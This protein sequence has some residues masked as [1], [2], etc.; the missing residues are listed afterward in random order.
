MSGR[1][2]YI[3]SKVAEI[4]RLTFYPLPG[5]PVKV[6]QAMKSGGALVVVGVNGRIYTSQANSRTYWST[7]NRMSDTVEA[8]VKFGMLSPQAIEQHKAAAKAESDA[9]EMRY[10]SSAILDNTDA[11]GIKL[12]KAQLAKL[13]AQASAHGWHYG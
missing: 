12:T 13:Q 11:A 7:L 8:L 6:A 5:K 9:R 1:G 3:Q 2:N 4:S 10:A